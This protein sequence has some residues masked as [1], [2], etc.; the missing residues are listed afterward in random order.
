MEGVDA[1]VLRVSADGLISTARKSSFSSIIG[2]D[3]EDEEKF[4]KFSEFLKE[5]EIDLSK[6]SAVIGIELAKTLKLRIGSKVVFTTQDSSGDINSISLR[7]KGIVQ[8]TNIPIDTS[9]IYVDINSLYKFLS[10]DETQAT[11]IS[12]KSDNEKLYDKL[13]EK[14]PGLNVKSFFELQPMMKMMQDMMVIFNSITFFIVMLVVFIG[15]LGVM[16]VSILDR[17]REFGIMLGIGMEYKYIRFQIILESLFVGFIG[18]LFGAVLGAILLSYLSI[19]GLNLSSFADALQSWGM[20]TVLY[21]SIKTSYF[22]STFV[23]IITASLLSVW[24]PLRK[25]KK[26]NPV[27]V[28]KAEK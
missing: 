10:I 13:K 1:I 17:V 16:Y 12:I 3:L 14:Y 9:G 18:Y 26:L 7:I 6:R 27:E 24:L 15:I 11:Q 4:G 19:Y 20:D 22:T 21:A 23:A 2:I 25:I 5:G 28:I 8:T